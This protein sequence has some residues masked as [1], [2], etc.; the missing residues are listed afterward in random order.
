ML[1]SEF[2]IIMR[3]KQIR[4]LFYFNC[5]ISDWIPCLRGKV[6]AISFFSFS[7][8][9]SVLIDQIPS[10]L[11]KLFCICTCEWQLMITAW[12][13][14]PKAFDIVVTKKYTKRLT[15]HPSK[16]K[17]KE[18]NHI[19]QICMMQYL[20]LFP[21]WFFSFPHGLINFFKYTCI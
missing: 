8:Q 18:T 10:V 9:P 20:Y 5:F 19:D 1:K 7:N 17:T 6:G 13:I 3:S 15:P 14:C 2:L 16:K 4:V 11:E 21:H 12:F